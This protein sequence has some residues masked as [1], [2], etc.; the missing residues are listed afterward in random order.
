M[1]GFFRT[2]QK[3]YRL[4][5]DPFYFFNF[6]SSDIAKTGQP[7]VG[8]S[9]SLVFYT[10]PSSV[11]PFFIWGARHFFL[12]WAVQCKNKHMSLNT[13]KPFLSVKG[14]NKVHR[15]ILKFLYFLVLDNCHP[16][17]LLSTLLVTLCHSL[18]R[19]SKRFSY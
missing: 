5:D 18:N 1:R 12:F 17:C 15:T 14:V 9:D 11:I 13:V 8:T 10:A 6:Q 4:I 2:G 19:Q 3:R 7:A 16:T